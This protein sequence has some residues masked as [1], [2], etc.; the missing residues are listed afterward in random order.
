[1][2]SRG[3]R[4]RRQQGGHDHG[5]PPT[6]RS[7]KYRS[8]LRSFLLVRRA[9]SLC[10]R[11]DL[12][13]DGDRFVANHDPKSIVGGAP[14]ANAV[15]LVV[16]LVLMM[17][18]FVVCYAKPLQKLVRRNTARVAPHNTIKGEER[19]YHMLQAKLTQQE[20]D[21]QNIYGNR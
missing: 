9:P 5:R 16:A 3:A 8:R 7:H 10:R 14:A 15:V 2:V 20:V 12:Q 13:N 21:Y 19:L 6:N 18:S 4:P 17:M 11:S 1:M